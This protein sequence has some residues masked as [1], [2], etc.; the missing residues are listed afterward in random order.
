MTPSSIY[1]RSIEE[2]GRSEGPGHDHN[3]ESQYPHPP[4]EQDEWSRIHNQSQM[5]SVAAKILSVQGFDPRAS[6]SYGTSPNSSNGDPTESNSGHQGSHSFAGSG[7]YAPLH[8]RC[9]RP[10][11]SSNGKCERCIKENEECI[12]KMET[13]SKPTAFVPASAFQ[14]GTP[15]SSQP[16]NDPSNTQP[17]G[18]PYSTGAS[19]EDAHS[20][21][22]SLLTWM[23]RNKQDGFNHDEI[24]TVFHLTEKLSN[25]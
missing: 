25:K 21:A 17:K 20:A 18:G 12:F 2:D 8:V 1:H 14:N 4:G 13:S 3:E 10:A 5:A 7:N 22:I 9:S 16:P 24:S 11:S 6:G 19:Q 15:P 23:M